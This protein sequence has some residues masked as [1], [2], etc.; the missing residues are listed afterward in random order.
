MSNGIMGED[1]TRLSRDPSRHQLYAEQP[2]SLQAEA[3][4]DSVTELGR[5]LVRCLTGG[6]HG[7]VNAVRKR[8]TITE[9]ARLDDH[10]LGD[11]GV[12]R[13]RIPEIALAL[14]AQRD[15]A[16]PSADTSAPSS[17]ATSASGRPSDHG[18]AV[19]CEES[20]PMAA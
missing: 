1:E 7:I 14:N 15:T 2:R 16:P 5:F 10:I 8:R 18:V 19:N 17:A 20:H 12:E 4:A 6:V 11:I 13:E 9:L 3:K